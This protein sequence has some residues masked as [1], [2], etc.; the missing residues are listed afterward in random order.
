VTWITFDGVSD[1]GAARRVMIAAA[2]AGVARIALRVV[3]VEVDFFTQLR[4]AACR[5]D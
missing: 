4:V 3:V 5:A 2:S 1:F